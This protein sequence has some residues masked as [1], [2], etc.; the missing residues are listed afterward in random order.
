MFHGH[1]TRDAIWDAIYLNSKSSQIHMMVSQHNACKQSF[2]LTIAVWKTM[3][4]QPLFC[5]FS[6][7]REL[8]FSSPNRSPGNKTI[9]VLI[10]PHSHV[11]PLKGKA[12]VVLSM[13]SSPFG[14]QVFAKYPTQKHPTF[15]N[16]KQEFLQAKLRLHS[17]V[18]EVRFSRIPQH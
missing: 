2:P 18:V 10:L 12:A 15:S 13:K 11:H 3:W 8:A 9:Q 7:G 1:K 14:R 4:T 17:S 6:F 5:P 16:A